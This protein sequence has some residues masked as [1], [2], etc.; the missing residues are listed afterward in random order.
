MYALLTNSKSVMPA[1]KDAIITH[2]KL[3]IVHQVVDVRTVMNVIRTKSKTGST[4]EVFSYHCIFIGETC[5]GGRKHTAS[6]GGRWP[7]VQFFLIEM[8]KFCI[9]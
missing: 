8:F 2:E 9:I 4:N 5:V 6:Q 7:K 1:A 3:S